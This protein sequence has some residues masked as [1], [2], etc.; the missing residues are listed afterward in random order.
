MYVLFVKNTR[1]V[2][3][4]HFCRAFA[5]T[6]DLFDMNELL[7][8]LGTHVLQRVGHEFHVEIQETCDVGN[9]HLLALEF[10]STLETA[11]F[12]QCQPCR[13][14]CAHRSEMQRIFRCLAFH[15]HTTVGK[16]LFCLGCI[17]GEISDFLIWM[18]GFEFR[19]C[20]HWIF[21][22]CTVR[23]TVEQLERAGREMQCAL[24]GRDN[25]ALD[26]LLLQADATGESAEAAADDYCIEFHFSTSSLLSFMS[27]TPP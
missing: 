19:N 21:H 23:Q 7:T 27:H 18:R 2:S 8:A 9:T 20:L 14:Q 5:Q 1:N 4:A 16:Q 10:F 17:F 6:V 26:A 15:F 3:G 24:S 22:S 12:R 13:F 11:E 25:G